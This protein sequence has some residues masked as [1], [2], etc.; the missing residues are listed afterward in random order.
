MSRTAWERWIFC[1]V[2]FVLLFFAAMCRPTIYGNSP[3]EITRYLR[4]EMADRGTGPTQLLAVEDEGAD[5]FA[6]FRG[7]KR[8]DER[9][10]VRFRQNQDG[11]YEPYIGG[12]RTM[13]EVETGCYVEFPIGYGDDTRNFF[14]A[15][16]ENPQITDLY[17]RFGAVREDWVTLPVGARC[18]VLDD[19]VCH[20]TEY[21]FHTAD[22]AE[23]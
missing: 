9:Y 14:V 12:V 5:R 1:A 6:V 17:V 13:W 18:V 19:P 2:S 10:L 21:R 3:G 11:D 8:P 23:F 7:E 15:W 4:R 20:V 22:G 16:C